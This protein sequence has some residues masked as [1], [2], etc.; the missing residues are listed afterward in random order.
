VSHQQQSS[1]P[2]HQKFSLEQAKQMIVEMGGTVCNGASWEDDRNIYASSVQTVRGTYGH[3]RY[4]VMFSKES[5]WLSASDR[6]PV[7]LETT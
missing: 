5:G 3:P 6:K 1:S 4:E 2:L 7:K